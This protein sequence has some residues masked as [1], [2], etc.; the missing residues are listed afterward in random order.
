[1]IHCGLCGQGRVKKVL[2]GLYYQTKLN[3][4]LKQKQKKAGS[5]D[6]EEM[7]AEDDDKDNEMDDEDDEK[8]K[9][10]KQRFSDETRNL[11][12]DPKTQTDYICCKCIASIDL[13]QV[14][15]LCLHFLFI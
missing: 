9:E 2:E 11:F 3:E 1:M 10:M 12:A 15:Y 6:K 7:D 13:L 8:D 4:Y 14:S 5:K